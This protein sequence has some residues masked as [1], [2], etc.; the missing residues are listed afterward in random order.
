MAEKMISISE[1][2]YNNLK[3]TEAKLDQLEINGVD[4]WVGYGCMCYELGTD[5]CIFCTEDEIKFLGLKD[6]ND[7]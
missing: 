2:E 1:S 6:K 4:N 5:E 7:N 3:I